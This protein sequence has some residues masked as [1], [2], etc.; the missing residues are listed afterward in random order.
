MTTITERTNNGGVVY[1]SP[2][3]VPVPDID[4]LT[5]LFGA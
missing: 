2:K 5:L 1:R 3:T 4:V